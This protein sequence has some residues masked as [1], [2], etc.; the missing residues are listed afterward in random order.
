MIQPAKD[1]PGVV[2]EGYTGID[3]FAEAI[4]TAAKRMPSQQIDFL[5]NNLIPDF[6]EMMMDHEK[7]LPII[8]RK[9]QEIPDP[10][11]PLNESQSV[12]ASLLLGLAAFDHPDK[13]SRR[14]FREV[15]KELSSSLELSRCL[16]LDSEELEQS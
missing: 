12:I 3:L 1:G 15:R 10:S 14:S 9:G 8:R 7:A 5:I 16:Q 6:V 4:E 11:Q 2:I 13:D